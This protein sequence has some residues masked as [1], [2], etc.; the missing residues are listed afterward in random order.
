MMI[1]ASSR[2]TMRLRSQ[3]CSRCLLSRSISCTSH[4]SCSRQ[5][6]IMTSIPMRAFILVGSPHNHKMTVLFSFYIGWTPDPCNVHPINYHKAARRLDASD[7]SDTAT[8]SNGQAAREQSTR[9]SHLAR[10][11]PPTASPWD[12][13]DAAFAVYHLPVWDR[14][15]ARETSNSGYCL[16][17]IS[18]MIKRQESPHCS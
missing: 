3:S 5:L 15:L 8:L 10:S 18:D 4:N 12:H 16:S 11:F 7:W 1:S 9:S 6:Q 14:N 13:G 17:W 2:R